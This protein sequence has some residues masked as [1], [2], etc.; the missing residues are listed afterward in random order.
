MDTKLEHALYKGFIAASG[1]IRGLSSARARKAAAVSSAAEKSGVSPQD[2]KSTVEKESGVERVFLSIADPFKTVSLPLAGKLIALGYEIVA[3]SG[4]AKSIR[5]AF[6]DAAV[7]D[8]GTADEALTWL[9][10]DK[11]SFSVILPTIGKI[12]VKPGFRMRRRAVENKVMCLTAFDTYF[13]VV[14][15]LEKGIDD[16][17]VDVFMAYS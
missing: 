1:S 14:S 17:A 15:L 11:I 8:A 13:A 5:D 12:K 9:T 10:R 16:D 3:T 6:P 4:T 2:E 7:I